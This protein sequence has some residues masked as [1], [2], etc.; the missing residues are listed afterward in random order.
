MSTALITVV[1][2]SLNQG[3]FLEHALTSIFQQDV[4]VE[5]YVMDGGSTDDSLEII[6]RWEHKLTGWKSRP[7][8]GQAAAINEGIALGSAPYVC[9]L[10]SDDFYYENGLKSLLESLKKYDGR[11]WVYGRC[12]TVS[13]QG[14]KIFPYITMPFWP[15]LFANFCFIAQPSTMI[16]RKAW[17]HLGGLT[18][19]MN[20]AFD[21]D[22]WWRLFNEYGKPVFYKRFAAATRMHSATKTA[23]FAE[24]HYAESMDVVRRH[25]G[26]VPLKWRAV[27]P[28]KR[29][30]QNFGK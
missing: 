12:W 6:K 7:D 17:E 29:T 9:W 5:V 13:E 8:E 19:G 10:N 11:Q 15:Q 4:P 2:P 16:T 20:L 27:L 21:Y 18:Q 28:I 23:N 14:S 22:F 30:M 1:V 25:W 26:T 3:T 24:D